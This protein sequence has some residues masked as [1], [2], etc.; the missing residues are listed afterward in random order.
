MVGMAAGTGLAVVTGVAVAARVAVAAGVAV[1]DEVDLM[2]K[3]GDSVNGF[4]NEEKLTFC[5]FPSPGNVSSSPTLSSS[6]PSTFGLPLD[7]LF[8]VN[9]FRG[10][11][12]NNGSRNDSCV[13]LRVTGIHFYCRHVD[14]QL[15]FLVNL[16]ATPSGFHSNPYSS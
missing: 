14:E 9:G 3:E 4:F 13:T 2:T 11:G 8:I 6:S 5:F 12:V 10:R 7:T 16:R 1:V 15:I